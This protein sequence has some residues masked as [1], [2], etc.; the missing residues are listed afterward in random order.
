MQFH[1]LGKII[2]PALL[3]IYALFPKS[4]FYH[5][6][7]ISGILFMINGCLSGPVICWRFEIW[8]FRCSMWKGKSKG[9]WLLNPGLFYGFY[10]GNGRAIRSYAQG[11]ILKAGIRYCPCC[12]CCSLMLKYIKPKFLLPSIET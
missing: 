5:S 12:K 11:F 3:F 1:D 8:I 2:V 6:W 9:S 7:A 4:G 10:F